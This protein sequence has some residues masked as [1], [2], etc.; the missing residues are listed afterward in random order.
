MTPT[1]P[2][3]AALRT[4]IVQVGRLLYEKS[5]IVAGDGNISA[6]LDDHRI[7]TTPSGL[8]KGMMSEDQLVIIDMAGRRVDT[9]IEANKHLRPT[10]EISMHVEVYKQRQDVQAVVHAHP[11]Y[12]IALSMAN[13]SLADCMLPEVIVTLGLIQT[14]PYS[15]PSTPENALAIR[16]AIQSHDAVVLQRHGSL[17]VGQ[18]PLDA[19]FKT[20]TVEQIGRITYM[21]QTLGGGTPLPAEQVQKLLAQRQA[22][23]RAFDGEA[24]EFCEACGV[25]H[26]QNVACAVA[27]STEA[28]S[29][30]LV[31]RI[32]RQVMANLAQK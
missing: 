12:A 20:E 25:C 30:D 19:F 10:S 24:A 13:I 7:L 1:L 3:E 23:G 28:P 9:P 8:C 32:T 26:P 14:M 2:L 5:L 17:T 29:A 16:Q 11:P 18:S 31:E 15:T 22:S 27:P 6:R 21:L 4:E